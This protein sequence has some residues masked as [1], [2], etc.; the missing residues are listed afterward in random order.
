MK[1]ADLIF[2]R[3]SELAAT[4]P[5]ELRGL[6][7]DEV[8]LLVSSPDGHQHAHFRDLA[9]FLEPGDL[10]VVN[11]SATLPASL[12]ASSSVGDFTLSLS[13]NFGGGLWIVE[14]RWSTAQPG[15]LPIH[16][17]EKFRVAGLDARFIQP[18]P[19]LNRL[20]LATIHGDLPTAMERFGKPIRYG[21][22]N[23]SYPMDFYQTI[24]ASVP[25]SAEMPSAAYPF[26]QRVLDSLS[27][28]GVELAGIVLHTGVSSL[29]VEAEEVESH[30]LY[31]EPF[32][33]PD[34]TAQAVNRAHAE[35]RRV[36]AVGTTCVRALESAWDGAQV[37]ASSGFTRVYIHPR[38]GVHTVDGLIS[39]L[40]DPVTSH[41][42]ML[43]AIAGKELIQ[44]GYSEAVH[45]GYL[46]HEFGDSHLILRHKA[47][48]KSNPI[49]RVA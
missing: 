43:Y 32:V 1:R 29:E 41:L 22:V 25:G 9:A 37:R 28:R 23:E 8:R 10:L 47:T 12:P 31:P 15:P 34:M 45:E 30:P 4:A 11:H 21:Y 26:T 3:P 13:T 18:Y 17:G 14:P 33:V 24:F 42:A 48:E 19:G 16:A 27:A 2:D 46:W 5:A 49:F 44:S 35:G 6:A 36:I 7:R 39:G 38:R 40:H 20:W